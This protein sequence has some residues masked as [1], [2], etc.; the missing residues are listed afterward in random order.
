MIG[1]AKC[2]YLEPAPNIL[3]FNFIL[4]SILEHFNLFDCNYLEFGHYW[5]HPFSRWD[6]L[7]VSELLGSASSASRSKTAKELEV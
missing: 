7:G 1:C 4:S 5:W 3:E 6:S 2:P